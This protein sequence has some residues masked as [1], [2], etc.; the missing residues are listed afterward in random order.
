MSTFERSPTTEQGSRPVYKVYK[1]RFWGLAQLVLLNIVVSWDWLTFS[2]IS[3]TAAEYFDVSES[4]INW[5]STGYLFAFCVV[6]PIV[7]WILNKGGPK[8]AIITTATLLLVGNWLR[9]AGTRANG[10]IYGLAMFG[11]ILIGFAQPF[12]LC[13]PTRYSE[14]WFS[15]KGRTSATAVASLANPLGAALGQLVDSEWASKPSDIPNMVLYISIIS[16]VA[17]IPSFFLPASPPTPA[18]ASSAKPHTPL[19]AAVRELT[20]T[21]EF[22]QIFI[23]FSVYVGFFNSVSSL[24]NQIL[25]P[26]GFSETEAG[27]AGAILIVVGLVASAIMSPI[28]DRYKH[29]LG[30]IRVLVPVVAVTYIGLIFAPGSAAGIPPSYV[31]MALLGAASFA[32][33]PIVLEYLAEITYP[34]SSEIGSTICWTGGQLLG[35]CFILIQDA[36][37]AGDGAA[38]PY[39]MRNALIFAAVVAVVAAPF[40]MTIGLF[41]RAVHRR[42]WDVDRGVELEQV[43]EEAGPVDNVKRVRSDESAADTDTL[44][45]T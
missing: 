8:P 13:A 31:V 27:I 25:S 32:M 45:K 16:T 4:A 33:L 30:S 26:H 36:L 5:M 15:D 20:R 29:Y 28:T 18:S 6:S 19:G 42:R 23:P 17:A 9:Y 10:G 38:P 35:A 24:L 2:S 22:W 3:T 43:G 37:K 7:I 40:P 14:L 21:R 1:R 34:L 12:C 11:Q 39:N 41:G 44:I